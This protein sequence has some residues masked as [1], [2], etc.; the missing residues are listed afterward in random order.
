[1]TTFHS[2]WQIDVEFHSIALSEGPLVGVQFH[3]VN[4]TDTAISSQTMAINVSVASYCQ[5]VSTPESVV[6]GES[7]EV[8]FEEKS[9]LFWIFC[10]T[11]ITNSFD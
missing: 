6:T 11:S 3:A 8:E 4:G 9:K 1:M 5:V 2:V 7:F 10:C